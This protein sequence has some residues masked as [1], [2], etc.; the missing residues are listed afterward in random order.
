MSNGE[1]ARKL[2]GSARE[3]REFMETALGRGS[4]NV[5]VREAFEVIELCLKAVLNYL[6]VDYPRAHDV[7]ELFINALAVRGI[8]LE[9][10]E[11]NDV[12]R[13]SAN[14][15]KTR[16]PASCFDTDEDEGSAAEAAANARRVHDLCLRIIADIGGDEAGA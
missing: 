11:A 8:E 2:L 16:A 15:A 9:E 5:A 10:Q 14:L 6:L 13:A 7:S 3:Y 1:R 4:W 12:R